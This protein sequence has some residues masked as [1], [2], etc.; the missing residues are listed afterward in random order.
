[1]EH[2]AS[3]SSFGS[4]NHIKNNYEQDIAQH[5]LGLDSLTKSKQEDKKKIIVVKNVRKVFKNNVVLKDVNFKVHEREIFGIIGLSGAGK[6]TLLNLLIG[7]YVP[8]EGEILV[9]TSILRGCKKK[10]EN[11]FVTLQKVYHKI[12]LSFG[13][14]S[15]IPSFYPDLS[16]EE[17]LRYFGS[18]YNVPTKIL[19]NNIVKLLKLFELEDSRKKR[20]KNL[21]GGMQKRVGYCM[22]TCT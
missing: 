19:N 14:A 6:T 15:Q 11:M 17:N 1:M 12:G 10:Q 2:K 5:K 4:I 16:V 20:A 21:S 22:C 3:I 13:F 7:Y 18:I 9:N 8:D